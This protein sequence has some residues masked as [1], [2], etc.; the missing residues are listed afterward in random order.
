[1]VREN[2]KLPGKYGLTH[3]WVENVLVIE[4]ITDILP[5]FKEYMKCVDGKTVKDAGR[6][7]FEMVKSAF[8][9]NLFWCCE[10]LCAFTAEICGIMGQATLCD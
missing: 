10:L 7:L 6:K 4:G 9:D 2:A 3:R 5:D 1:M 8:R